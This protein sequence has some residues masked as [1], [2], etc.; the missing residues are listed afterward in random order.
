MRTMRIVFILLALCFAFALMNCQDSVPGEQQENDLS[1][2]ADIPAV[3]DESNGDA[4]DEP[5]DEP[6]WEFKSSDEKGTFLTPIDR[7]VG[8]PELVETPVSM[9]DLVYP[10]YDMDTKTTSKKSVGDT[11]IWNLLTADPMDSVWGY[12]E[13]IL[14]GWELEIESKL[15]E[16]EGDRSVSV[17]LKDGDN[18][19]I[20]DLSQHGTRNFTRIAITKETIPG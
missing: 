6:E 1:G 17:V 2:T 7:L 10:I 9:D 15:E 5:V 18:V 19:Y 4:V 11:D 8:E 12:Y 3:V 16:E 13:Q 20:I 14:E